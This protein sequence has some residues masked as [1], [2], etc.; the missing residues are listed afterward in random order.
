MPKSRA[1]YLIDQLIKNSLSERELEELLASMGTEEMNA[2]YSTILEAY[3]EN[4]LTKDTN[5]QTD[6]TTPK[7]G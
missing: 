4:L 2:E 6:P 1:Q 3:F 7:K 5:K